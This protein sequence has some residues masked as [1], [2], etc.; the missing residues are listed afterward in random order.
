MIKALFGQTTS[1]YLLR[2]GLNE[3]MAAHKDVAKR[4]A[5]ALSSSTQASADA[6]GGGAAGA[7]ES[8]LVTDMA[9]LADVQIRYETEARLLQLVYQSLRA[10]VKSNG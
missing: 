2:Q 1:P 4:I 7:A 9:S 6:A 5:G 10:A 8:D 3:S